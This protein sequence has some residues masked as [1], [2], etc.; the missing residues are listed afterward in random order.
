MNKPRR[1]GPTPRKALPDRAINLDELSQMSGLSKNALYHL[2]SHRPSALP[3]PLVGDAY[4]NSA[5]YLLSTAEEW[6]RNQQA[7]P[8]SPP[9]AVPVKG[10]A[11][12]DAPLVA[13]ARDLAGV[14]APGGVLVMAGL[15]RHQQRGVA[16]A[17]R[18]H[19]MVPA[20]AMDRRAEWPC[21]VL[22]K[23]RM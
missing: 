7:A 3:P 4:R 16:N 2:R 9:P 11:Q 15:L 12:E 8:I 22:T 13:L 21:L 18:R 1:T 19:G 17:Y 23:K 5:M 6:L 10:A 14:I 20:G